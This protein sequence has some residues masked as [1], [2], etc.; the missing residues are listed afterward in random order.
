MKRSLVVQIRNCLATILIVSTFGFEVKADEVEVYGDAQVDSV[1][2]SEVNNA[3]SSHAD[4]QR[5]MLSA[6]Y[7]LGLK[8]E[9]EEGPLLELHVRLLRCTP[10][11]VGLSFDIWHSNIVTADY[12]GEFRTSVYGISLLEMFPPVLRLKRVSVG[13][14]EQFG[15]YSFYNTPE[16]Y[17]E[18]SEKFDNSKLRYNKYYLGNTLGI[19][20]KYRGLHI[21]LGYTLNNI[22]LKPYGDGH[23][24]GLFRK[25]TV[26]GLSVAFRLGLW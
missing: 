16:Y 10:L 2:I 19:Y 22:D 9:Y 14:F 21:T 1:G 6:G 3:R 11:Y 17:H 7:I 8:S 5:V 12:T 4:F 24:S 13:I 20:L 25:P 26:H 18:P 15:Y 23:K